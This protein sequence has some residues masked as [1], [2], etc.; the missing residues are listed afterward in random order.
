[1]AQCALDVAHLNRVR[2]RANVTSQLTALGFY[3]QDVTDPKAAEVAEP[4]TQHAGIN[5]AIRNMLGIKAVSAKTTDDAVGGGKSPLKP[6]AKAGT[7]QPGGGNSAPSKFS[8]AQQRGAD[9]VARTLEMRARHLRLGFGMHYGWAV[10]TASGA[11]DVGEDEGDDGSDDED[12][13]AAAKSVKKVECSYL[14]PHVNMA[15]RLEIATQQYGVTNLVSDTFAQLLSPQPRALL[16]VVDRVL[17]KGSDAPISLHT[18]DFL[19]VSS[20][21]VADFVPSAGGGV[22]GG[23]VGGNMTSPNRKQLATV[24]S[25][26]PVDASLAVG[27]GSSGGGLERSRLLAESSLSALLLLQNPDDLLEY[28]TRFQEG[29]NAYIDGSWTVSFNNLTKCQK[30]L[31]HDLPAQ[32]MMRH[33]HHVFGGGGHSVRVV[34]SIDATKALSPS[35]LSRRSS[36]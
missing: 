34:R 24:A 3:G 31:P 27:G 11:G 4:S 5:G 35:L 30:K 9:Q 25:A 10:E 2:G 26:S 12:E 19:P 22:D 17:V 6:L 13:E 7:T 14:S 1:M 8:K 28:Q 20:D 36:P 15:S 21:S 33:H 32:V 16:R 18:Y 29:I 23:G